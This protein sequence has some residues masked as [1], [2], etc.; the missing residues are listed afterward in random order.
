M[1]T[2]D[3]GGITYSQTWSM[4]ENTASSQS[5]LSTAAPSN[6]THVLVRLSWTQ[7]LAIHSPLAL[8]VDRY[9]TPIWYIIGVIGNI[10]SAKIWLERRMRQNN[11]SAIY[12]AT[13]SI[14]DLFFLLLHTLQELKYAWGFNTLAYPGIC[15]MYFLFS[16]CAQYLSPLLVLGFTVERWIAVCRPFHKEKYCTAHRA[17]RVVVLLVVISLSLCA[18]QAYFWTYSYAREDC[19]VR[20]SSMVGDNASLWSIYSWITEM[21]I[22]LAVPLVILVFNILVIREVRKISQH[23]QIMLSSQV[24]GNHNAS[25]ATTVMLLSVSF[26][27]I[28]TTLPAT[29]V[30]VL[31]SQFPEGDWYLTDPEIRSS[32]VWQHYLGYLT[33]RKIT[34][35]ICLSHY[36][37]NFFLYLVTGVQFRRAVM[38]FL[39]CDLY[40]SGKQALYSEVT[41]NTTTWHNNATRPENTTKV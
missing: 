40:F 5:M 27:V 20:D 16:L 14:A 39:K 7:F 12:L 26:Y 21:L 8:H 33:F 10:L 25:A 35:E 15:E 24:R 6:K 2:D 28:F 17:I 22:F 4:L 3:L 31:I 18:I 9:V 23:G 34:E 1:M 32:E 19:I 13:L 36:A 11:S 30:Y 29:L 37:C 41:Q 38:E